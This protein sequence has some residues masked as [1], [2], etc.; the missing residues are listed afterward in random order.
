MKTVLY[1]INS[2][3]KFIVDNLID[4]SECMFA[5]TS[6]E[7]SFHEQP[8]L[9]IK[10]LAK[11]D[12]DDID[13]VIICSIYVNEISE[14]LIAI[15]LPLTKLAFFEFSSNKIVLCADR[16]IPTIDA[17]DVLYCFYDLNKNNACFDILLFCAHAEVHRQKSGKK[18]IHF[19]VVPSYGSHNSS[20]NFVREYDQDD[21]Q[22]RIDHIVYPSLKRVDATIG[23]SMLGHRDEVKGYSQFAGS[24]FPQ[25]YLQDM[26][27]YN[28][29]YHELYADMQ[30][31]H[32]LTFVSASQPARDFAKQ[33]LSHCCENRKLVLINLRQYENQPSRNS[34]LEQWVRFAEQLDANEYFV[35]FIPDTYTLASQ[36]PEA[37]KNHHVYLPAALDLDIRLAFYELAWINLS[38][39]S[40]TSFVYNFMEGVPYI[41]FLKTSDNDAVGNT[42][43]LLRTGRKKDQDF[44]LRNNPFQKEI[45]H[46]DTS[47]I[48]LEAFQTLD[49]ALRSHDQSEK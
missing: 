43:A 33:Y 39:S 23:V 49:L 15:G 25:H 3:T 48:I 17:D 19:V 26:T 46:N 29:S 24:T 1:G 38:V 34:D 8:I 41:V 37:L 9:D 44:I 42:E 2:G 28:L 27:G 13:K 11:L 10:Q 14:S 30:C 20:L 16:L 7:G 47:D 18:H 4:Q 5:T 36:M 21:L 35:L 12:F 45:W 40:G 22:W 31:G 6:G 32:R